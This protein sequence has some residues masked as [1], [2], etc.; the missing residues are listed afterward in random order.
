MEKLL[1]DWKTK[2]GLLLFVLA[3]LM[4]SGTWSVYMGKAISFRAITGFQTPATD[5]FFKNITHLGDGIFILALAAVL[6]AFRKYFLSIGVV[7]GY[8]LSGIFAQIGK[9]LIEAPRPKAFFEAMGE[10]VYQIPGVNVHVAK[11]FPSGHTASVFA[12]AVFLMLALPY[13]WYSWLILLGACIVGYSRVY[14]SQ[15][16]PVDVVAGALIGSF[17]GAAVFFWLKSRSERRNLPNNSAGS[18]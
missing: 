8:L 6:A 18:F 11:S 13:R 3:V 7:A 17:S 1:S 4:G 14:V 2:R 16:F 9:R 5:F 10:M 12:L 15:H